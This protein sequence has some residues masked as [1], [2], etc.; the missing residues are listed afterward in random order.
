[1]L[2]LTTFAFFD[3]L[4]WR[5]FL[6]P[7]FTSCARHGKIKLR[8]SVS[9]G[10]TRHIHHFPIN[11]SAVVG[12]SNRWV[13]TKLMT[14]I[15]NWN[16]CVDSMGGKEVENKKCQ[17]RSCY[18]MKYLSLPTRTRPAKISG[19][20]ERWYFHFMRFIFFFNFNETFGKWFC[21]MS[22]FA[23]NNLLCVYL[24]FR[25][26]EQ[27]FSRLCAQANQSFDLHIARMRNLP[28][29]SSSVQPPCQHFISLAFWCQ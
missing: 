10:N 25:F 29:E 15:A 28:L 3:S 24:I 4:L 26:K 5:I 8:L 17:Q 27:H 16:E 13:R 21:E 18:I 2:S 20:E 19:M 9:I 1:M 23:L 11:F 14:S 7:H 12:N 6:S 22:N